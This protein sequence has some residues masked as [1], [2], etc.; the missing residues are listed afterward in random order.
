M[1]NVYEIITSRIIKQLETGVA[2]WQKPW[3]TSGSAG[4]P[5]NF[6]SGRAYRGI[7]VW[8]LLTSGYASPCWLTFRQA[9]E[10]G[11]Y[12]RQG[13]VGVPVVYWKFGTREVRDG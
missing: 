5:R 3:R 12:V 8:I 2:P 4:V 1:A 11:G 13:E 9:R 10:L 7:N 6:I